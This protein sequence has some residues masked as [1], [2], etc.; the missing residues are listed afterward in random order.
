[1]PQD[2]REAAPVS[3]T[4]PPDALTGVVQPGA[5]AEPESAVQPELALG[6]QVW[7]GVCGAHL[8]TRELRESHRCDRINP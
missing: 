8:S 1:M 5:A 3:R 2:D 6:D 7:C 4:A